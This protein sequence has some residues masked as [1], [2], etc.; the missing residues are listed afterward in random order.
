[1][2]RYLSN[3]VMAMNPNSTTVAHGPM[4]GSPDIVDAPDVVTRAAGVERPIAD[5]DGDRGWGRGDIT[6]SAIDGRWRRCHHT[7][8]YPEGEEKACTDEPRRPARESLAD[9]SFGGVN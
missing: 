3:D 1:M 7:S 2:A 9:R 4:S 8:P 5:L 6:W